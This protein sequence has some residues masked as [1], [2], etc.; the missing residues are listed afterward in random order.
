MFYLLVEISHETLFSNK[1]NHSNFICWNFWTSFKLI[2]F[3]ICLKSQVRILLGAKFTLLR[4]TFI[5][6][7]LYQYDLNSDQRDLKHQDPVVQ[8]IVSLTSLLVVK[9]LTVPVSTISNSHVFLLKKCSFLQKGEI[10]CVRENH[11]VEF[12][13]P[14]YIFPFF[15]LS[16]QCNALGNLCQR[17]LRN[18]CTWYFEIWYIHWVRLFVSC[19]RDS[20]SSCLSFP[21]FVHFCHRFLRNYCTYD[22]E[23]CNKHWVWLVVLSKRESASSCWSFSEGERLFVYRT[24]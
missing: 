16:L 15:H 20:A 21:L 6:P 3:I 7:S 2:E 22:F 24:F 4:K 14:F 5:T 13:L 1:K 9:V 10:C 8:S 11:D 18:Y 19:K 23:I 17:F 12:Y